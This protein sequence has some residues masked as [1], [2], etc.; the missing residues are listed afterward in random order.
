MKDDAP[1]KM[2]Q[3]IPNGML[4]DNYPRNMWWVAAHRDEVST[5]P[6]TRWLLETPVVLYRLDDG[7]PAALYDRCPH[8][9][10]PLSQGHVAGDK[11]V[12]PYHG[13]EF[14][15][16]GRCTKAPTQNMMPKTANIPSF[17]VKETGAYIWIWMG[18]QDAIDCLM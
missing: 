2:G 10:A 15:T 11:I 8:R 5:Q 9:W 1:Q 12:C 17:A 13:M 18:D 3:R 4:E 6:I 7:T 14:N 16:E